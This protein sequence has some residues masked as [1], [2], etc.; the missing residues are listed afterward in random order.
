MIL[1]EIVGVDARNSGAPGHN[2]RV[3]IFTTRSK[4]VPSLEV[5][6]KKGTYLLSNYLIAATMFFITYNTLVTVGV[7]DA[8]GISRFS[9]S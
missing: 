9:D 4:R 6:S 7:N 8:L 3:T 2:S 5:V 1:H